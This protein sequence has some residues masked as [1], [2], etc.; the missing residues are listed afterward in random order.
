MPMDENTSKNRTL[1]E[2]ALNAKQGDKDALEKLLVNREIKG[3]IY[4]IANEKVGHANADDVYQEVLAC[5]SQKICT[6]QGQAEIT[7][8][9]NRITRNT[10]VD[11]LRKA[12]PNWITVTEKT[13][14]DS[15]EP[16]QFR[17]ISARQILEI[18]HSILQEMGEECRRLIGLYIIDGLEKQEI[19]EI[20]KLPKS[21][22]YR[23]WKGCYTTLIQK[24]QKIQNFCK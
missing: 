22:F 11:F 1:Y 18:T 6:W 7:T 13:L 9:I 4:K 19:M 24:I 21:T 5:I 17:K 10:C 8:W 23:K 3:V 14:E 2:L 20:V 15:V 12:K 16:E